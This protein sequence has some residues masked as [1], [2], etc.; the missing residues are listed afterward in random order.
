M[1]A[2][3]EKLHPKPACSCT[4]SLHVYIICKYVEKS[5]MAEITRW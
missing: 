1:F 2:L 5:C 4:I 3:Q